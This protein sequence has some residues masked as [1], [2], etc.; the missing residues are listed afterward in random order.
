MNRFVSRT[1][2]ELRMRK[3]IV[4][5]ISGGIAVFKVAQLVSNLSKKHEV[6]VVMTEHATEIMSPLT[7]ETLTGRKALYKMFGEDVHHMSVDHIDVAKW[8]DLII[9]APATANI[10]AKM[11]YGLAD[12]L[13]STMLLAARS[14]ILVCPAM[15]SFMLDHPATT[16]NLY[17]LKE[18]GVEILESDAGMLACGD[19]GSGKLPSPEQIQAKAEEILADAGKVEHDLTGLTITI[20][21]G[22]TVEAIDPVRF[23]SNYS[24][25]K[26]GYALAA[27]AVSRGA[28]VKL[29]SGP[30]SLPPVEG[31]EL[32]SVNSAE[33][34]FTAVKHAFG[35]TH[36]LIKAAAVGDYRVKTE[37][38]EKLK[39]S[40]EEL[41]IEL[42]K[43]P[44][45]LLWAGEHKREDMVICG[46]AMETEN[47]LDNA[48]E[49]LEKKHCDLLVANSLREEGAGFRGDTNV[50]T[51]LWPTKRKAVEKMSKQDLAE[52]IL[53]EVL[54]IREEKQHVDD[55]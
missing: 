13:L 31:A 30:V 55:H 1:G 28:K 16:E 20:T 39:K 47:L 4:V 11:T 29:I 26:M 35:E 46:F 50:V 5:G 42:V 7:F 24:S 52:I 23:I 32:I 27:K 19:F 49:K 21:A 17:R 43:N 6:Q 9:L 37:A 44:D 14:P 12:D 34:M 51:L 54:A 38:T 10:I 53:D 15:N 8:A 48:M 45:I 40:D 18:R 36:I 3:K 2:K 25:G 33:E 22:P 41:T